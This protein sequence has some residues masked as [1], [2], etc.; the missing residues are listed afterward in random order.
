MILTPPTKSWISGKQV[1]LILTLLTILLARSGQS[2]RLEEDANKESEDRGAHI[3]N[4]KARRLLLRLFRRRIKIPAKSSLSLA[5]QVSRPNI[6]PGIFNQ[7][8]GFITDAVI[9]FPMW[10]KFLV[11]K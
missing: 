8:D 11:V 6:F 9:E 1:L 4:K 2:D 10:R 5:T 3:F 7:E